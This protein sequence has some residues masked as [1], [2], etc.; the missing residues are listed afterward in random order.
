MPATAQHEQVAAEHQ[1]E[2]DQ[3]NY[4]AV[5]AEEGKQRNDTQGQHAPEKM[6]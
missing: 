1:D 2:E 3:Q 5:H 4:A 6:Q